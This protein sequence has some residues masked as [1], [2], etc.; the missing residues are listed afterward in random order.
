MS[1][2]GIINIYK[3]TGFTSHDVVAVLRR[4]L[5]QKKIG[6]TGTLD[7]EATG[8]L[9]VCLGKGTKLAGILTDKDKAYKTTLKLGED[10]T[11]GDHTGDILRAKD[12][13]VTNEQ[14][15]KMLHS[16]IGPIKQIP[17]MYSAIKVGGKKLY[18]LAREGKEIERAPR[19]VTIYDI[20]DV[21]VD[22]PYVTMTVQ[23]SKGTYIRTL[24][25]DIAHSLDEYGHMCALERIASGAFDLSTSHTLKEVEAKIAE[26][27]LLE[28]ITPID[29]MF[30]DYPRLKVD[31]V[32]NKYLYNG[33][34][35]PSES[36]HPMDNLDKL[37]DKKLYNVYNEENVYMGIYH[38]DEKAD[39]LIPKTFFDL[40]QKS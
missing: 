35:L 34:K 1:Y 3:E 6:H 14:V 11:T 23:C 18:E 27:D 9:P 36:V 32:F 19:Q 20:Y 15:L 33:N 7:P 13:M 40:R 5:K 8:V 39:L 26:G 28:W 29:K 24:C 31:R 17:P 12:P 4:L 37:L 25:E 16:F 10:R 2:N 30:S 21:Q 38:F 22:L